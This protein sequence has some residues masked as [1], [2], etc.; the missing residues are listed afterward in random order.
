MN[1][2]LMFHL[3][4]RGLVGAGGLGSK[5][6]FDDPIKWSGRVGL[7]ASICVPSAFHFEGDVNQ[8]GP[9]RPKKGQGLQ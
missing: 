4:G 5:P 3:H 6:I 2:F 7:L 8:A 1:G 9:R